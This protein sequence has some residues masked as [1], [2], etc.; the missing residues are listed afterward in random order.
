MFSM[1][2]T[3][4]N[5]NLFCFVFEQLGEIVAIQKCYVAL[6]SMYE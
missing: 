4:Y 5:T 2:T 6:L 3:A 1:Q